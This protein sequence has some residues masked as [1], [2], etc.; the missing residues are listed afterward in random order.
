MRQYLWRCPSRTY[1]RD[2]SGAPGE[3]LVFKRS[4]SRLPDQDAD[5]HGYLLKAEAPVADASARGEFGEFVAIYILA[6]RSQLTR[7]GLAP[8]GNSTGKTR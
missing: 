5:L 7:L 1:D 3:S 8:P 4:G 2:T 6:D